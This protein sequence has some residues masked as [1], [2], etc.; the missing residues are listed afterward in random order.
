VGGRRISRLPS[1]D[2]AAARV[3]FLFIYFFF[4]L[5]GLT[6]MMYGRTRTDTVLLRRRRSPSRRLSVRPGND[7]NFAF[8]LL[9][10]ELLETVILF[11]FFLRH[12]YYHRRERNFFYS[13]SRRPWQ[14]ISSRNRR[15]SSVREAIMFQCF[16]VGLGFAKRTGHVYGR[17]AAVQKRTMNT[18]HYYCRSIMSLEV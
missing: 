8:V 16:S 17:L 2:E 18:F 4:L 15:R 14:F 9:C 13:S 12:Y 1:P 5:T 7:G 6:F 10:C 11:F 3:L